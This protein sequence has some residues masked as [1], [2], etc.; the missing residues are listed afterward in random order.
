MAY[1]TKSAVLARAAKDVGLKA[2][3]ES[4]LEAANQQFSASK[5][6]DIFLSHSYQD[7]QLV[8]GAKLKLEDKG[9]TVYVDWIDD[10]QMSRD[11]VN[12][13]TAE[14]L[15]IRMKVCKSFLYLATNNAGHSKWMP[16][17]LGFFDGLKKNKIA[18]LPVLANADQDFNGQEYLSLYPIVKDYSILNDL[19]VSGDGAFIN[20]GQWVASNSG[21]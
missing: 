15:R 9:F 12:K 19:Y 18:I 10:N 3:A 7:A 5:T 13:K 1:L 8:L 11:N 6:Y 4:L 20:L 2:K 16:W 17:E 21:F 14:T